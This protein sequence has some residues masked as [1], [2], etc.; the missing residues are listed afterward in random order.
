LIVW[1]D[2]TETDSSVYLVFV[3]FS[4]FFLILQTSG[5]TWLSRPVLGP[6]YGWTG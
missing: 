1:A 6:V 5:S 2:I 3:G 4:S